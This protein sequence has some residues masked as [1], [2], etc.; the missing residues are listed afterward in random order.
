MY[1]S[2]PWLYVHP[3]SLAVRTSLFCG[4][5]YL[6]GAEVRVLL[7]GILELHVGAELV[8]GD[9]SLRRPVDL[10]EQRVDLTLLQVGEATPG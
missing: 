5:T 10:V 4:C 1:F 6:P 8:P 7:L 2:A 9:G 3:C